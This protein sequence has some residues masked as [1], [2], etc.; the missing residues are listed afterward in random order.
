MSYY[1]TTLN[2]II[3]TFYENFDFNTKSENNI[4]I[5]K[6]I[7]K[8]K[9]LNRLYNSNHYRPT[10]TLRY[11]KIMESIHC[12]YRENIPTKSQFSTTSIFE[13]LLLFMFSIDPEL[14]AFIIYSSENST[15]EIRMKL[16]QKFGLYDKNLIKT[17]KFFIQNFLE[18]EKQND[19]YEEIDKRAFK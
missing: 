5:D 1:F 14:E 19:I 18:K 2:K 3:Y 10:K 6:I 11:L 9:E 12:N 4:E 7:E 13:K 16:E 15:D 8:S 17:E